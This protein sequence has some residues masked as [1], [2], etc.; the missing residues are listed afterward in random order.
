[1]YLRQGEMRWS[2]SVAIEASSLAK[3][4]GAPGVVHAGSAASG[5]RA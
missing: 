5:E 1:M 4:P 3:F 2:L